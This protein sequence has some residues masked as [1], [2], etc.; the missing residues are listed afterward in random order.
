M[1]S[2]IILLLTI[3]LLAI[4]SDEMKC[5]ITSQGLYISIKGRG[6][7]RRSSIVVVSQEGVIYESAKR[8]VNVREEGSSFIWEDETPEV[9]IFYRVSYIEEG[10]EV[11]LRLKLRRNIPAFLQYFIAQMPISQ[12]AGANFKTDKKSG[13]IPVVSRAQ[14]MEDA[15]LAEDFQYISFRTS[16][17]ELSLSLEGE[18]KKVLIDARLPVWSKDELWIGYMDSALNFDKEAVFRTVFKFS[19]AFGGEKLLRSTV[20]AVYKENLLQRNSP[21]PVLPP[22]KQASFGNDFFLPHSPKIII[23]HSL[24][25]KDER[26]IASLQKILKG[27]GFSCQVIPSKDPLKILEGNIILTKNESLIGEVITQGESEILREPLKPEGYVLIVKPNFLFLYGKDERGLFNGVQTIRWILTRNGIRCCVIKDYPA[28]PFRGVH[29]FADK[30]SL[31]FYLQLIEKVLAPMKINTIVLECEYGEWKSQPKLNNEWTMT[32]EEIKTLLR[33]AKENFIDVYPLIQSFGHAEWAFQRGNNLDIAED[34]QHPYAFCPSN[35]R[36]YSFLFSI[37]EEAFNLFQKPAIFHIGADEVEMIGRF[38]NPNCPNG[39]GKKDI[40]SLYFEHIKKIYDFLSQKGCKVMI[41]GDEM[42]APGEAGDATHAQTKQEAEAKRKLLPKDII[43]ADWHYNPFDD[44]P[45]IGIFKQA[46]FNNIIACTWYRPANIYKF[47][48][49][50]YRQGAMGLLQTTWAGFYNVQSLSKSFEQVAPYVL[51]AIY[52]WNPEAPAPNFLPHIAELFK[53]LWEGGMER[54][55]GG[56]LW[57]ISEAGLAEF[58]D[59]P[60]GERFLGGRKFLIPDKKVL[61]QGQNPFA[62]D[63]PNVIEMKLQTALPAKELYFLHSAVGEEPP[64]TLIG[65]Y[66]IQYEDGG[67]EVLVLSLGNNIVP[68]SSDKL[69]IWLSPPL[70]NRLPGLRIFVWRNPNPL[71][72]IQKIKIVS[73]TTRSSILLAGISSASP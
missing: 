37:Y 52:G 27:Q 31:P 67:K 14:R 19:P 28:F 36:T 10:V 70:S 1:R 32:Q 44:Y 72:K 13:T 55:G 45:S 7:V 5:S 54:E 57:D 34:P 29:F 3:P 16:F 15:I 65:E 25:Q 51:S 8:K 24:N 62:F 61:L 33:T 18:G 53:E 43:I 71:R 60:S 69:T 23:D 21:F 49:S 4:P 73:Y 30:S 12:F 64:D 46:G 63:A 9:S 48:Q 59:I 38:P 2:V 56:W 58:T 20:K 35:P 66:D 68:I 40:V 41:W 17:G 26:T 42:L 47:A 50:A 39:C 22:P 11:V 6:I